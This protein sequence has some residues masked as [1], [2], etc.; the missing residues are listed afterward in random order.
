MGWHEALSKWWL[1]PKACLWGVGLM[2]EMAGVTCSSSLRA[3]GMWPC[4]P[5]FPSSPF[6]WTSVLRKD[7]PEAESPA[8]MLEVGWQGTSG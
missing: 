5:P 3:V 4:L 2:G 7:Y 6:L 8:L 1:R